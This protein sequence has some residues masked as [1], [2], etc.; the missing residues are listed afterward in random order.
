LPAWADAF[1]PDRLGRAP[2]LELPAELT[3]EWAFGSGTGAGVRVAVIDSGIDGDHPA[4]GG[5]DRHVIVEYDPDAEAD[6]YIHY[7]EGEHRD[8]YGHGNAC[9]AIIRALAPEIELY[10]IRVLGERLTGKA[11]CFAAGLDWALQ[12]DVHVVNM[13]LSTTNDDWFSTFHDLADQAMR[14]RVMVVCALANDAKV[15]IPAEFASV[16]SVA[17]VTTEDPEQLLANP[18]PPAEWGARGIDV[19]VAW[20]DGSSIVASGNSFAA[21][22]VAGMLARMLGE[23]PGLTCWQAKTILAQLAGNR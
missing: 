12:H 19:P 11:R 20:L 1:A 10:S 22:H 6:G 17:A 8:L 2:R 3:R 7:V 14:R 9:A 13:S 18:A 23:H 5:V 21:P 4:V 15:S 16:F